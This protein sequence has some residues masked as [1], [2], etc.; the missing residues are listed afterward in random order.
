MENRLTFESV[1]ITN[2]KKLRKMHIDANGNSFFIIGKNESG[3]SSLIQAMVS[4]LDTKFEPD[5]PVTEG[6]ER[7]RVEL[8]LSGHS[9]SGEPKRYVIE[10]FYSAKTNKGT[11]QMIN[12]S[13]EKIAAPKSMLKELVG[14]IS[15]NPIAFIN[16]PPASKIKVLRELSGC[17]KE[18]YAAEHVVKDA[19]D[20]KAYYEKRVKEL[21][22]FLKENNLPDEEIKKYSEEID[23]S[24]L[25][26][27]MDDFNKFNEKRAERERALEERRNTVRLKNANIES[28]K[29]EEK[30]LLER[31]EGIRI[32]VSK[33]QEENEKMLSENLPVQAWLEANPKKDTSPISELMRSASEH[34]QKS[35]AIQATK[36]KYDELQDA[37]ANVELWAGKVKSAVAKREEVIKNSNLPVKGL[38]WDDSEIFI[39]GMPWNERQISKSRS[40]EIGLEIAMAMN[41]RLKCLF[42]HDASLFDDEHLK[43]VIEMCEERGYQ[44][45]AEVVGKE[46]SPEIKFTEEYLK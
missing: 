6:E 14:A 2:F 20:K 1:D 26:S 27:Q 3:K 19:K 24:I 8:V 46:E 4:P 10:V 16:S 17:E 45:I 34:N 30:E 12:E 5:I 21:E 31:I 11:L 37:N 43:K 38:S 44:I 18:I 13:G 25:S 28:L 7:G 29:R 40:L 39:D 36:V 33:M 22:A 42:L 23:V 9:S 41:P 15:F 32:K 35:K